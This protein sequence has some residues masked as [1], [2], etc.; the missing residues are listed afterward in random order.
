M[1]SHFSVKS[2]LGIGLDALGNILI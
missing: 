1:R 2:R